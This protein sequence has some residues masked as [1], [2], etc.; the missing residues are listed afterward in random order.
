MK[1]YFTGNFPLQI[2]FKKIKFSLEYPLLGLTKRS[3]IDHQRG[4]F[5]LLIE[6]GTPER[7]I[8]DKKFEE[9]HFG[10][11]WILTCQG[12]WLHLKV[13][14]SNSP[15]FRPCLFRLVT[16]LLVLQSLWSVPTLEDL[17]RPGCCMR[18]EW[19]LGY[20][21][22]RKSHL[23]FAALVLETL[24]LPLNET[25]LLLACPFSGKGI[26]NF[27]LGRRKETWL[28]FFHDKSA[29]KK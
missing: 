22:L 14:V 28:S 25:Q 5:L 17:H 12:H 1:L 21:N 26:L 11:H 16:E 10:L 18:V 13:W 24:N 6:T 19:T 9:R 20:I 3:N 15:A 23:Y 2:F 7:Q 4:S 8:Q 29:P 27:L